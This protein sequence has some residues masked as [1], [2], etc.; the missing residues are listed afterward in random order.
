MRI[1]VVGDVHVGMGSMG[2][3]DPETRLNSRL[4]DYGRT[5]DFICSY[6][7]KNK[8]PVVVFTGD[9]YKTRTPTADQRNV[10]EERIKELAKI[11]S[12][13]IVAGNHDLIGSGSSTIDSFV[14]LEVPNVHIYKDFS[15]VTLDGANIIFSPFVNKNYFNVEHNDEAV[16]KYEEKIKNIV[17]EMENDNPNILVGHS[18][19]GGVR[20]GSL[21]ITEEMSLSELVL[22]Q[23]VFDC[24]DLTIMGHVHTQ[25]ILREDIIYVGSM[26][27]N[28]FS[29]AEGRKSMLK[30]DLKKMKYDFID[31]PVRNIY[32]I[33]LTGDKY[34]NQLNSY[35]L[36]DAIVK[37]DIHCNQEEMYK[38]DMDEVDKILKCK[39]IYHCVH[40]N[41]IPLKKE[42]ENKYEEGLSDIELFVE[43]IKN[44]FENPEELIQRGL[45]I[46]EDE[47]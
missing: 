9:M 44:N 19:L 39:G 16:I 35:E 1:L 34:L 25:Q 20:I 14:N 13:F 32:D 43:Y 23:S 22:P 37:I 31:L 8:V 15:F 28:D 12:V 24:M 46:I 2:K 45:E 17:S 4:L 3:M 21:E 5:L 42:T 36:K 11:T 6:V 26:E 10:V 29:E 47:N 40:K 38:I 18:L 41:I 7:K 27:R 30:I 33:T